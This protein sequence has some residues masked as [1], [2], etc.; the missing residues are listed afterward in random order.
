MC[1]LFVFFCLLCW[2]DAVSL[3][4]PSVGCFCLLVSGRGRVGFLLF[5]FLLSLPAFPPFFI[6]C[7]RS[8]SVH[9][10]RPSLF[11]SSLPLLL[12][13]PFSYLS[14]PVLSLSSLLPSLYYPNVFITHAAFLSQ[15]FSHSPLFPTSPSRSCP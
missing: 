6:I 4:F 10:F 13:W 15:P 12:P 8:P 1:M 5:C 9:Y 14:L 7:S 2:R 11:L 3:M